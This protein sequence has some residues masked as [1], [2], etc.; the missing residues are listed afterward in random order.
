[1]GQ[2]IP[3]GTCMAFGVHSLLNQTCCI[4][5]LERKAGEESHKHPKARMESLETALT[6]VTRESE[7]NTEW[8]R[9]EARTCGCQ[10]GG[11]GTSVLPGKAEGLCHVHVGRR[12]GRGRGE[13]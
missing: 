13:H 8:G 10:V 1:M 9:Q 11:L 12:V 4:E 7:V 5:H 2:I 6:P 3:Y